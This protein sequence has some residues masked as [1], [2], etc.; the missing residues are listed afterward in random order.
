[1]IS[2]L[3]LGSK[4]VVVG[5]AIVEGYGLVAPAVVNAVRFASTVVLLLH[6]RETCYDGYEGG[7]NCAVGIGTANGWYTC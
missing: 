3:E 5:A 1:M 7:S 4:E 2:L 6:S